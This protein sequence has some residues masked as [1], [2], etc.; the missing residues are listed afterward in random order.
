[1]EAM[2]I[3]SPYNRREQL[4]RRRRPQVS[5]PD[6]TY[7]TFVVPDAILY[8][9]DMRHLRRGLVYSN[10]ARS[11][12]RVEQGALVVGCDTSHGGLSA[13]CTTENTTMAGATRAAVTLTAGAQ[14]G[15]TWAALIVT[16]LEAAGIT[17]IERDG[18]EITIANAEVSFPGAYDETLRGMRGRRRTRFGT[19]GGVTAPAYTAVNATVS[20]HLNM[21]ATAGRIVAVGFNDSAG[22]R[23]GTVRIGVGNG[24]DYALAS[25]A[26]TD[27]V[28][29]LATRGTGDAWLYGL[30]TPQASA[31]SADKWITYRTNTAAAFQVEIRNFTATPAGGGDLVTAERI[32]IDVTVTNPATAIG[33]SYTN[34]AGANAQVFAGVFV[35]YELPNASGDY[36]GDASIDTIVGFRLAHD[37]GTASVLPAAT[38]A[39]VY[40][41]PRLNIPANWSATTG[42]V[43]EWIESARGAGA[44]DEAFGSGV[45]DHSAVTI[46]AYPMDQDAP[47]LSAIEPMPSA[48][49]AGYSRR[50]F[51]PP[52]DLTGVTRVGAFLNCGN[53]DGVTAPDTTTVLYDAQTTVGFPGSWSTGWVDQAE[54]SDE[55]D[56][57]GNG[58]NMQY[59]G[60]GSAMPVGDPSPASSP[61]PQGTDGADQT[62]AN[63]PRMRMRV[64]RPGFRLAA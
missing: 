18:A 11:Y 31:S 49:G 13:N 26:M 40:D 33:P 44:L 54:W 35:I 63:V 56:V 14:T 43:L 29:G 24:P 34:P 58:A 2:A 45:Y 21:P 1:M 28:D 50:T 15:A 16:A 64:R 9:I 62:F 61:D 60:D 41:S 19:G 7:V 20:A 52:L 27:I 47:L 59:V 48:V 38:L 4:R 32:L 5:P 22:A 17:G 51:D 42:L 12:F 53:L 23:T 55:I 25:T 37:V 46:S 30:P 10:A 6:T 57:E 36:Y 8:P 39:T 3:D